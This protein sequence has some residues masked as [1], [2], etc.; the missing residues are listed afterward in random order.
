MDDV[1]A[2]HVPSWFVCSEVYYYFVCTH[3]H[4]CD[5]TSHP[6]DSTKWLS[7]INREVMVFLM[8]VN[9][10]SSPRMQ[11]QSQQYCTSKSQL[12]TVCQFAP[13]GRFAL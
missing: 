8:T 12:L 13:P 11:V 5:S 7:E 2:C 6:T 10:S 9:P 1:G 3:S 4:L